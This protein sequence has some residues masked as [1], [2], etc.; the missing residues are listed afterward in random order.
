MQSV[1]LAELER[2]GGPPSWSK[3]ERWR[4]QKNIAN[5]CHFRSETKGSHSNGTTYSD[6]ASR[7]SERVGAPVISRWCTFA[8][9]RDPPPLPHSLLP[10]FLI[11]AF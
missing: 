10:S 9:T 6:G 7:E 11:R 3:E 2:V 5:Y 8:G 1:G 4:E